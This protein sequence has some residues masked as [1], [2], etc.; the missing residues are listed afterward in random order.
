M[1][2]YSTRIFQ[3]FL[4]SAADRHLTESECAAHLSA[5]HNTHWRAK[6]STSARS[7]HHHCN[8]RSKQSSHFSCLTQCV[9]WKIQNMKHRILHKLWTSHRYTQ[10]NWNLFH[11]GDWGDCGDWGHGKQKNIHPHHGG[12]TSPR[13]GRL[14]RW[15][16]PTP[17]TVKNISQRAVFGRHP[18]IGHIMTDP[19]FYCWDFLG[20][21]IMN[22]HGSSDMMQIDA[23]WWLS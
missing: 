12:G 2:W 22:H 8:K 11:W 1:T 6:S 5:D 23:V 15:G 19:K 3:T 13:W 14:H 18:E 4:F 20:S 10:I 16:F 21:W 9:V 7:L 17:G